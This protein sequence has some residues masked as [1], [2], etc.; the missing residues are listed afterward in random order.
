MKLNALPISVVIAALLGIAEYHFLVFCWGYIAQYTPLLGW[1]VG[2][3]LKG[4]ALRVVLFPIDFLTSVV[5]SLPAAYLLSVLRPRMLWLYVVVAVVPGFVWFNLSLVGN[6]IL[7]QYL[8][9]FGWV[10]ELFALPVA[11]W[12]L[13]VIPRT[14]K[15]SLALGPSRGSA[16]QDAHRETKGLQRCASD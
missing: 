12:L 4:V 13:R 7:T 16:N 5:I 14:P 9:G 3:G 8:L 6:P 11:A 10:P 15:D 2:V 1:L